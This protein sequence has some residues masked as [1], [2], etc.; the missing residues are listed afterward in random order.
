[1][2]VVTSPNSQP[3]GPSH[4]T[5]RAFLCRAFRGY[6]RTPCAAHLLLAGR[7]C[8]GDEVVR[9]GSLLKALGHS[10][11]PEWVGEAGSGTAASRSSGISRAHQGSFVPVAGGLS[12]L[13][14]GP[15]SLS[16]CMHA[17]GLLAKQEPLETGAV[18]DARRAHSLPGYPGSCHS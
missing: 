12:P 7:R 17:Q 14:T 13:R 16:R 11:S 3:P 15:G 8:G 4:R 10:V 1:M 9:S 18:A 6:L 2:P 5:L